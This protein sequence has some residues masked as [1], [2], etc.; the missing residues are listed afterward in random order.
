M[1]ILVVSD[2]EYRQTSRGIDLITTI[3]ADR[4]F[5]VDHLVFFRRKR[6]CEKQ[7]TGNIRQLYFYDTIKLYHLRLQFLFPDF[8]LLAYFR[9]MIRKNSHIDF[10]NYDYVV[11]ESGHPTYLASEI[12]N[13]II[14][15][16]SDPAD[17]SFKSKRQIYRDLETEVIKRAFFTISAL[18]KQFYPPEYK[19]RFFYCHSGFIPCPE[20]TNQTVK[21]NIIVMGGDIDWKLLNKMSGKY[22]E[23]KFFVIGIRLRMTVRRNI[24][25]MGYLEY[26]KYQELLSSAMLTVIP[27][28]DHYTRYLQQVSYTAKILVSMQLGMPILLKEYGSIQKTDPEKKLFVYNTHNEALT[29]FGDIIKKIKNGELNYDVSEDTQSFLTPQTAENRRKEMEAILDHFLQEN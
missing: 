23:Y 28:S 10:N 29:M 11:L 14:Y 20:K 17:A 19:D 25:S 13:K 21:K 24:I 4:G 2:R 18:E 12:N 7:V 3:L 15:R 8:L 6:L 16:Q 22:P 5:K 26:G 1:K 27:F 9:H